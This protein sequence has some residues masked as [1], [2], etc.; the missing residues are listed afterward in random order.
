[1]KMMF[2]INKRV[3]PIKNNIENIETINN[4]N[5]IKIFVEKNVDRLANTINLRY[6]MLGR[7]QNTSNCTNCDK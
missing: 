5:D 3:I 6:S 7:I 4:K 2:S 1:M